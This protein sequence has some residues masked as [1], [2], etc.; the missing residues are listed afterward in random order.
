MGLPL[1]AASALVCT[2]LQSG[3]APHGG[4]MTTSLQTVRV[5]ITSVSDTPSL[6]P[7]WQR[8]LAYRAPFLINKLVRSGLAFDDEHAAELFLE[9]KKYLYLAS[10]H[11]GRIPMTSSLV[12]AAWHQFI[13]YTSEYS[14]FCEEIFGSYQHHSPRGADDDTHPERP[15]VTAKTLADHYHQTFGPLPQLWHNERCLTA[16]TRLTR[17]DAR[18]RMFVEQD[19]QHA[20]LLRERDRRELVCRASARARPALAFIAARRAFFVRELPGL[21]DLTE[22]LTLLCPLVECDVLNVAP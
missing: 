9:V 17:P 14:E 3:R 22:Q 4:P 12:D 8:L 19:A 21:R 15:V 1:M 7:L 20:L 11:D 10:S 2:L 6:D 16:D 13:L 5:P 18:Q